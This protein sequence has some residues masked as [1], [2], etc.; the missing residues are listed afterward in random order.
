MSIKIPAMPEVSMSGVKQYMTVRILECQ[1]GGF[2][3]IYNDAAMAARSSWDEVLDSIA[4]AGS[5]IL[6]VDRL[7]MPDCVR[8]IEEKHSSSFNH[9]RHDENVVDRMKGA[10]HALGMF[11]IGVVGGIMSLLSVKVA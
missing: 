8:R 11:V 4:E 1:R 3:I 9:D 7:P 10:V 5:D 6:G 2:A